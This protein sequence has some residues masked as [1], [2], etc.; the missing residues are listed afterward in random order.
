MAM[1]VSGMY[2]GMDTESIIADLVKVKQVKVDD[3]KKQQ[4]K[5]QWKQEAWK[6]L[7]SKIYKL[8]SGTL[9]DLTYQSS[10]A[11]KTTTVSNPSA[12]TVITQDSAMHSVQSLKIKSLASAGYMTGGELADGTTASTTM[13]DLLGG[14]A[15]ADGGTAKIK[16]TIGKTDK[17]PGEVKEI[18][19]TADS[20]VSDVT[21]KL[22]ELGLNANYDSAT[23]R[24]F[25]GA[26]STG[27]EN[28]FQISADAGISTDALKA[29]G[30]STEGDNKAIKEKGSS[31]EIELNGAK[32]TSA[33]N[34]F[35]INGLT[36]T[37]NAET[38]DSP[39]TLTTQDDT[40]GIY[41]M[42]KDFIKEYTGLI[43][44]MDKLYNA[45]RAKGYEPLTDEE[46]DAMSESEIEKWETKIK[47]SLLK[48]DST[49][50]T[51]SSA[52]KEIMSSGFEVG[53]KTMYL[54][55]FGIET[56]G[57]FEAEDNQRNAYYINGDED[58]EN[59]TIKNKS[60]DLMAAIN[61]DPAQVRDFFNQLAKSLKTKLDDLMGGTT[62]ASTYSVY[63]DKKMKTEYDEY[64]K[65]IKEA[66]QKLA[67]YE[68]K[69][70][71][72]FAAME[73]AMAK[74]QSNMNAVSSMFGGMQ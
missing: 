10:F 40:S 3:L 43:N 22:K 30:L 24:I 67:D 51:V 19:L 37:C 47:D 9:S 5:H 68:D 41:D 62:Y 65:K 72:K 7:N 44:E 26:S 18:E 45:D 55:D 57:Y 63:E 14:D 48:G 12:A 11:K 71:K 42:V 54:S 39:I 46:K 69:W 15:F 61:K 59:S 66:E 58:N 8:F 56:M 31:A 1:R 60:N 20:K 38:G 28:D 29:L 70:Y 21:A 64:T 4:T 27:E 49:L 53:G 35:E 32:F 52:M 6:N 16:V 34:T 74:M 25:I 33:S 50:S 2:S 36:I 23:N 17:N 13:K 73:T